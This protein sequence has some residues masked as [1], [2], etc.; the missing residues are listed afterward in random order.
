VFSG[1]PAATPAS[2]PGVF[3]WILV[4]G[5]EFGGPARFRAGSKVRLS[6]PPSPSF[7]PK[8]VR[9]TR[10]FRLPGFF[11]LT[12][13]SRCMQVPRPFP[14]GFGS[15]FL[16]TLFLKGRFTPAL[17]WP[18]DVV[19]FPPPFFVL[20]PVRSW[21]GF[22]TSEGTTGPVFPQ[23][24]LALPFTCSAPRSWCR[25]LSLTAAFFIGP[26]HSYP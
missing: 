7:F 10:F 18:G 16:H 26:N 6:L 5:A 13:P 25:V 3:C 14:V 12:V 1:A 9:D 21:Q 19:P 20:W 24:V 22:F 17:N 23:K 4:F 8:T 11:R 2:L 15:P